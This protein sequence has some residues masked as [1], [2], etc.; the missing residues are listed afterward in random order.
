MGDILEAYEGEILL[1]V[2]HRGETLESVSQYLRGLFPTRRGLSAISLRRYCRSRGIH[3]RTNLSS[4]DLDRV[5]HSA[6]AWVGHSY[7]RRTLHG[8]LRSNGIHVSQSRIG[9]SLRRVF[10]LAHSVRRQTLGRT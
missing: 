9:E 8:L 7:G 5:I 4:V 2:T 10:P 3:Y 6:V 1:R